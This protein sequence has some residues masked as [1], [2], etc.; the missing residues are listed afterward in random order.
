[1]ALRKANPERMKLPFTADEAAVHAPAVGVVPVA[2]HPVQFVAD[3][4]AE[5]PAVP[6]VEQFAGFNMKYPVIHPVQ[7]PEFKPMKHPVGNDPETQVPAY[8][9]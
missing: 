8:D 3:V 5:H 9:K 1:M 2:V 4:H 6:A 7:N